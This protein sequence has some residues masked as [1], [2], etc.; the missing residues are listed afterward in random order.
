MSLEKEIQN[1]KDEIAFLK[2]VMF[3]KT[4]GENHYKKN[5]ARIYNYFKK[6]T[7]VKIS[8]SPTKLQKKT[9]F[10]TENISNEIPT[11]V[12][13]EVAQQTDINEHYLLT[14]GVTSLLN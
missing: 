7:D 5:K 11:D 4:D 10:F 13:N 9:S 1:L 14:R 12:M 2:Q 3:T 6:N 8:S